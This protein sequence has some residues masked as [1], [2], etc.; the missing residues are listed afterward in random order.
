MVAVVI[1]K[2]LNSVVAA[3]IVVTSFVVVVATF[4]DVEWLVE[5]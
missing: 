4:V 3:L 5:D 2:D 1:T